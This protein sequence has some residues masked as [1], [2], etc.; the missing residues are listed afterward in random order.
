MLN[1]RYSD[2][3]YNI[4]QEFNTGGDTGII[5]SAGNG[6][7]TKAWKESK[8][9]KDEDRKILKNKT[10]ARQLAETDVS[11]VGLGYINGN[12]GF[13]LIDWDEINEYNLTTI[14]Y[15]LRNYNGKLIAYPSR[16]GMHM[17]FKTPKA[18][19]ELPNWGKRQIKITSFAGNETIDYIPNGII[20]F[21]MPSTKTNM[22]EFQGDIDKFNE[23]ELQQDIVKIMREEGFVSQDLSFTNIDLSPELP[24]ILY[25]LGKTEFYKLDMSGS[26]NI[27]LT[28]W[29]GKLSF[30]SEYIDTTNHIDKIKEWIND[31]Y[32]GT[33]ALN[34]HEL[35]SIT[36]YDNDGHSNNW[37][38]DESEVKLKKQAVKTGKSFDKQYKANY[39]AIADI[40][41]SETNDIV[42]WCLENLEIKLY[43]KVILFKKYN[44]WWGDPDILMGEINSA[45]YIDHLTT[46]KL[47]EFYKK[48]IIELKMRIARGETQWEANINSIPLWI[49]I[50]GRMINPYDILDENGR[51]KFVDI[52]DGI[53]L[54]NMSID[55]DD[56]QRIIDNK[57]T[58]I[59]L[60][61]IQRYLFNPLMG[62][63][64]KINHMLTY[65]G[66]MLMSG[67]K[68]RKKM[69]M[70]YSEE[71]NS[72]KSKF[73]EMIG[74]FHKSNISRAKLHELSGT[75]GLQPLMNKAINIGD[76]VDNETKANKTI[77]KTLA[78]E[79][80]M[81]ANPKN[82]PQTNALMP[83]IAFSMNEL[84]APTSMDKGWI[85]RLEIIHW[86]LNYNKPDYD[87]ERNITD[88]EFLTA[89]FAMIIKRYSSVSEANFWDNPYSEIME[90]YKENNKDVE[91]EILNEVVGR[92]P[93]AYIDGQSL[94]KIHISVQQALDAE[95]IRNIKPSQLKVSR[96]LKYNGYVKVKK[97]HGN[98]WQREIN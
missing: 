90:E 60:D 39:Q 1:T 88:T 78:S 53:I 38:L 45:K 5:I 68:F 26:R 22:I 91:T 51:L 86:R 79:M 19:T 52:N 67:N 56:V 47:T 17:W 83:K 13:T 2:K 50:K 37:Y 18:F 6:V 48:L 11:K 23:G 35:A 9:K 59:I 34:D 89:V 84:P 30:K 20:N 36:E 24:V 55:F 10:T 61:R 95:S 92:I 27:G 76:D 15:I 58:N 71:A 46:H 93:F 31:V 80:F 62:D 8:T 57:P 33:E 70:V 3:V 32:L 21:A 12:N 25:P 77:L 81:M 85:E 14:R 64:N 63:M 75:H 49:D 87:L 82:L 29:I 96:A 73:L 66:Y 7:P 44:K 43:D 4:T 41:K 42:K 16:K 54:H 98:V 97:S 69:L 72:G 40:D 65:V 28:T 94:G 74:A